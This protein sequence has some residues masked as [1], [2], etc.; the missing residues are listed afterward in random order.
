MFKRIKSMKKRQSRTCILVAKNSRGKIMMAADRLSSYDW[1][2]A[3][4]MNRPKITKKNKVLLGACGDG[5]LCTLIIDIFDVPEPPKDTSADLYMFY[6]FKPLL[7]K[8][9]KQQGYTDEHKLLQIPKESSCGLLVAVLG[10]VYSVGIHNSDPDNDHSFL[11]E[12]SIDV[13]S[14]PFAIG[15]GDIPAIVSLKKDLNKT[16]YNTKEHVT[17]ALE[18]ACDIS[19]GC[20]LSKTHKPDIVV[21]D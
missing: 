13:S 11:G 12:V 20:G 1:G 15:C 14:T 7:I 5:G 17:E 2:H 4:L 3:E 6:L 18:L 9:L 21:E 16:G 8:F 10:Q 19:P